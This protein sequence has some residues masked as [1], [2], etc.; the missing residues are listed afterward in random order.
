MQ[1][2]FNNQSR[3]LNDE[4]LM[5][6]LLAQEKQLVSNYG[7][8]VCEASCPNLRQVLVGNLTETTQD[9][10]DVFNQMQSRGW[11]ATKPANAPDVQAAKQ[12]Y[13]QIKSQIG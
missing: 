1:N 5:N 9:Q 11:Y 4:D 10:F 12:K 3:Q 6:D 2:Q 7:T 8:Y 13:A